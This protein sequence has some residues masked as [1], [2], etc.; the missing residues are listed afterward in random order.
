MVAYSFKRQFIRPI[1]R[2]TKQQ[3][4]RADRRRHARP[5]EPLQIYF[6]MRTKSCRLIGHATCLLAHPIRL[7][8][9][10]NRVERDVGLPRVS[11]ADLDRFAMDDG[12]ADWAA[13]RSFW[14]TEHPD[15]PVFSGVLIGW[16][17][18][19]RAMWPDET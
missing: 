13:M 4:I 14:R 9:V 7:D 6:G 19:L 5:G 15:V 11:A 3:T 8:F 18:S 1:L 12:F 16:G 2:Q 17:T 10:A